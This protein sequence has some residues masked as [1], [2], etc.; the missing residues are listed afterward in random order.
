[1]LHPPLPGGRV[2]SLTSL[3]LCPMW[4]E[5]HSSAGL[6][7]GR[8]S[9]AS[10]AQRTRLARHREVLWDT[11]AGREG[12]TFH[13]TGKRP[14]AEGP[15]PVGC[16]LETWATGLPWRGGFCLVLGLHSLSFCAVLLFAHVPPLVFPPKSRTPRPD[17]QNKLQCTR[18]TDSGIITFSPQNTEIRITFIATLPPIQGQ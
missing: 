4:W 14:S 12:R 13:R 7:S 5:T 15:W 3:G 17:T 11:V 8:G 6:C 18:T 16:I 9:Q 10:A 1:M 2:R